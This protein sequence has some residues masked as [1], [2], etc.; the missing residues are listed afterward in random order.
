M[1]ARLV[2]AAALAVAALPAPARATCVNNVCTPYGPGSIDTAGD[3][4]HSCVYYKASAPA[5]PG[6]PAGN[7]SGGPYVFVRTKQWGFDHPTGWDVRVCDLDA[8]TADLNDL[9]GRVGVS[10]PVELPPRP[11]R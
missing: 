2:V 3:V 11:S 6:W 1:R 9:A 8:S 4:W 7:D 10:L 5:P